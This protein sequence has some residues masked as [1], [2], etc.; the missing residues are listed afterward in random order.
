MEKK[1]IHMKEGITMNRH[2]LLYLLTG[3]ILA[4][5]I[6]QVWFAISGLLPMVLFPG[7][8]LDYRLNEIII[9]MDII[10]LPFLIAFA[11]N[12][13]RSHS[14]PPKHQPKYF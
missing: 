10:V 13:K 8:L 7:I 3:F 1:R 6:G 9:F 4:D 12:A 5:L 14:L 2:D 11:W